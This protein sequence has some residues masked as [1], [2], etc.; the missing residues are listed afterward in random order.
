MAAMVEFHKEEFPAEAWVKVRAST[1]AQQSFLCWKG[2]IY[3]LIPGEK[4][5]H[6]FQI[7]GMSVARCIPLAEGGWDFTSREVTFYLDPGTGEIL[8]RWQNPWT[9]EE[10][11]VVHV[12]NNPVQG[13][14]KIPLPAV[15]EGE[16]ATFVFDLF[17][18]YPNPLAGDAKFAPYSPQP[19]YQATE[20]FKLRVST[21][22]LRNPAITSISQVFL[23][24]DRIGP[25]LPWMKMADRPGQLI[26]SAIGQKIPDFQHLPQLVQD[27]IN[28]RV[29]L[30]KNAPESKL[31]R[32]EVTSW[33]YF[34]KHFDAYLRG[35]T[36]PIPE[37]GL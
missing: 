21:A 12:A 30:Y 17:S 33:K 19:I 37:P 35:E 6:L 16:M 32:D 8:R 11:P 24:W 23:A 22:E 13:S 7:V 2:S 29:P 9:G 34:E 3:A 18:Q 14:F 31:D 27:E 20:L 36:F 25:W 28:S 4:K 1:D 5:Q 15:V 10:V 26:Y